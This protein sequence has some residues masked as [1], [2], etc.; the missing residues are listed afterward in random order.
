[1]LRQLEPELI[2]IPEEAKAYAHARAVTDLNQEFADDLLKLAGDAENLKVVDLGTG[3][4]AIPVMLAKARP[5]WHITAVDGARSILLIAQIGI[6]M[7]GLADR[8][9]VHLGDARDTKLP[10]N[11]FD[12]ICCNRVL[13]HM[14]EPLEFWGEVKRLARPGAIFFL[15]DLMRPDTEEEARDIVATDAADQS[16]VLKEGWYRSLL[17]A[18]KVDEVAQQ[19]EAAGLSSLQVKR[20]SHR[21]LD[22]FGRV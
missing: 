14:P 9:K 20:H 21:Y 16:D 2:D 5:G 17:A 12:V 15:R 1:M 10:A 6:K 8:V 4:A 19:L 13:H 3:P 7:A 11:S 22:V 18:F